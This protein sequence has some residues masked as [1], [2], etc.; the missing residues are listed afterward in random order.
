MPIK[1]ILSGLCYTYAFP[2]EGVPHFFPLMV[3]SLFIFFESL[4]NSIKKNLLF[5]LLF[6]LAYC[7]SG[8]Y[9]I[10]YTLTEFGEINA[11]FN[12]MLG[13]LFSLIIVPQY[14]LFA[15]LFPKLSK[16]K[17]PSKN[18]VIA[19]ILT[20]FEY[21]VPQQFP[22]H[23]G[24][25][26]MTFA[27][28][29]YLAKVGGVPF[30]SFVSYWLALSL[31]ESYRDRK[32]DFVLYPS[33]VIIFIVNFLFPL[34]KEEIDNP[35]QT[36]IKLV[37]GH[38]NN[39][40]KISSRKGYPEAVSE[41]L[42]RYQ[43]L[44]SEGE[45]ADL[46]IW[47]ETSYPKTMNTEFMTKNSANVP[48]LLRKVI[49]TTNSQLV[50][51]GYALAN[52]NNTFYF[53]TEYNSIFLFNRAAEYQAAYHKQILIPFGESLPFG[54][55]NP[56]FAKI[57]KNVS[58]FAKGKEFTVFKLDN[59]INAINAICYEILFSSFIKKYANNINDPYHF[60]INLTNDSWYGDTAEPYQHRFLAHW[61]ALE[62]NR[63]IV[64]VTNT[65]ITSVLYPD[66]SESGNLG[67]FKEGVLDIT[68]NSKQNPETTVFS[69]L[70][71][72]FTILLSLILGAIDYLRK[73]FFEKIMKTDKA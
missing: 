43:R 68:L 41:V 70:G 5:V 17:I 36:K 40:I 10:P 32:I 11:P 61:R 14:T 2:V 62:F 33:L 56:Y 31:I 7:M 67:L 34:Q 72:T 39:L 60:I 22:A 57:I 16:L 53:E 54:P 35:K 49:M 55:L 45:S 52:R 47:P 26:W 44:S 59:G 66:G 71:I 3:V 18:I 42:A 37:Q 38:I 25:S 6:S 65:G 64:R 29:L 58:F 4:G 12:Y 9:W 63:P 69:K 23:P 50:T 27:P 30:F 19:L 73:T 51:G 20:L 24:H 13:A 48:N 21:F 46:I 15:I 28:Y 8:Y 1:A